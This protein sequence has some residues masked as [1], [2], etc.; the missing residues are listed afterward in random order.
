MYGITTPASLIHAAKRFRVKKKKNRLKLYS[1]LPAEE[2]REGD[3]R[4]HSLNW[5]IT[6][7]SAQ[8][9]LLHHQQPSQLS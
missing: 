2:N 5:H 4:R 6:E 7:F 9:V 1:Q 3:M 8:V